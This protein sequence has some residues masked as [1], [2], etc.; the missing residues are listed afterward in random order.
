ML[1]KAISVLLSV[2]M[3]VSAL[4]VTAVSASAAEEVISYVVAGTANLCDET[5]SF[6]E[7]SGNIVVE[8]PY[9]TADVTLRLYL[10]G[11]DYATKTGAK[12]TVTVKD[13]YTFG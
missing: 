5:R 13:T 9:E 10:T 8:V 6:T 12:F 4:S 2:M 7:E 1:K 11:F 3:I